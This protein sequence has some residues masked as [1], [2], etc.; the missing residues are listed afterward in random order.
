MLTDSQIIG[1]HNQDPLALFIQFSVGERYYIY[2][3]D[4][5]TRFESVKEELYEKKRYGRVDL[6]LKDEQVLLGKI[7]FNP[8]IKKVMKDYPF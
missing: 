2:E 6:D 1:I 7:M 8:K 4:C 5:V 3:R